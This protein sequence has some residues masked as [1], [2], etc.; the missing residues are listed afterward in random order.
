MPYFAWKGIQLDGS[1]QRGSLFAPSPEVLDALLLKKGIALLHAQKKPL[2]RW[3]YPVSSTAII[4]LFEQL[5]ALVATGIRLPQVLQILAEQQPNPRLQE[6]LF[7]VADTVSRGG[8]LYAAC[9]EFGHFFDPAVLHQL[10]IGEDV[11]RLAQ[12]AETIQR[13][14]ERKAAFRAQMRSLLSMPLITVLFLIVVVA[15][16]FGCIMPQF[17]AIF[18]MLGHEVPPLT[19]RMMQV[20]VFMRSFYLPVLL[21][22]LV[23]LAIGLAMVARTGR[24][25]V[26][27]DM[28]VLRLPIIKHL[29]CCHILAQTYFSLALLLH[30]GVPLVRA[31]TTVQALVHNTVFARA[32][33]HVCQSVDQGVGLAQALAQYPHLFPADGLG[34]IAVGQEASALPA[35]LK[36]VAADYQKKLDTHMHRLVVLAQPCFLLILGL[37]IGLVIIAVYTPIMQVAYK[38]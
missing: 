36:A 18:T 19:R 10:H 38:I 4:R 11:G 8:L 2:Y 26:A 17:T 34:V 31:L 12:A 28:L 15:L 9:G 30:E 37:L 3:L 27:K 7:Y 35:M 21:A 5:H 32:L 1:E 20:S 6:M 16:I 29:V 24:G 13:Y 14:L 22:L 33:A 25:K 23:F